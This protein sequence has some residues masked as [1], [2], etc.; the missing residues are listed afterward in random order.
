MVLMTWQTA[1]LPS[2]RAWLA[3][4]TMAERRIGDLVSF[5]NWLRERMAAPV[6]MTRGSRFVGSWFMGTGQVIAM[7][8]TSE[9]SGFMC[10]IR[11][12]VKFPQM[13]LNR[14]S[15]QGAVTIWMAVKMRVSPVLG[16]LGNVTTALE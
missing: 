11:R 14:G 16:L 10:R 5:I 8:V 15:Y 1:V 13:R 2:A 3:I 12:I 7:T 4:R 9:C 6:A